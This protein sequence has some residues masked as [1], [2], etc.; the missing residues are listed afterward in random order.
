MAAFDGDAVGPGALGQ[1]P[2]HLAKRL[3]QFFQLIVRQ[4]A[5]GIDGGKLKQG[6]VVDNQGAGLPSGLE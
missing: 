5:R 2:S 3:L 1:L 6:I 4:D